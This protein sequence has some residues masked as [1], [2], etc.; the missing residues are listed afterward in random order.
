MDRHAL[1]DSRLV[2][3]FSANSAGLSRGVRFILATVLNTVYS[4]R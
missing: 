3:A 1:A 2:G 4:I